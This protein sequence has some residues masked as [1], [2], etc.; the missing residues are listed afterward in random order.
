MTVTRTTPEIER[1]KRLI[2]ELYADRVRLHQRLRSGPTSEAPAP[3][4]LW[5]VRHKC[6]PP[7]PAALVYR[8][9]RR[10]LRC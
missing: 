10:G 9:S 8:G 3:F 1:I 4:S 5:Q 2:A 6:P 7:L